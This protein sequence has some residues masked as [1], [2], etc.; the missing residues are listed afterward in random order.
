MF[1]KIKK[2]YPTFNYPD[3]LDIDIW[4]EVLE[5]FSQEDILRALK[6]YRKNEEYNA[7]PNPAK[8]KKFLVKMDE[9]H[10][11]SAKALLAET[12]RA[13]SPASDL[14]QRDIAAGSCR[15][16]LPIYEKAV[17]YVLREQLIEHMGFNA[18]SKSSEESRY[19]LALRN[20]LF[21]DFNTILVQVCNFQNGKDYQFENANMVEANSRKLGN[22]TKNLASHLRTDE[23]KY[24]KKANDD[25]I[26]DLGA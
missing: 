2:L 22:I 25:G 7:A 19:S 26:F 6:E 20:G 15:H 23:T 16:L 17:K 12:V 8:F 18:C 4:Q 10:P 24:N 14:M 3:E 5:G 13:I 21:D 1:D 9:A 11:T